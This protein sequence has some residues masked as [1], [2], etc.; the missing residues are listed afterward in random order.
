MV[1]VIVAGAVAV[2]VGVFTVQGSAQPARVTT[3]GLI[4]LAATVQFG[5]TCSGSRRTRACW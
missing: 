3:P 2:A 1:P 5:A 4:R